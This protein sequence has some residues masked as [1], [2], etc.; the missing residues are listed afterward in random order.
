MN[1]ILIIKINQLFLVKGIVYLIKYNIEVFLE[2]NERAPNFIF[3]FKEG[4]KSK[5]SVVDFTDEELD[6]TLQEFLKTR[7]SYLRI[8][9]SEDEKI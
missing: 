2:I 8:K 1:P 7:F 9:T 6:Q 3:H 5:K 4:F